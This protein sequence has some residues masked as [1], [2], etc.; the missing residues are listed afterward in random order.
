MQAKKP[1]VQDCEIKELLKDV[2]CF[3]LDMDGTFFLGDKLLPG[4]LTFMDF[5]QENGLEYLFLTNNSSSHAGLYAEKIGRMGFDVPVE[6]IFTSGAATTIYL[7]KR[8]PNA[9]V[10]L[11]GTQALEEEFRKS[12]FILTDDDPDFAVLGFDT[13][14]TYDKLVKIC[15]LVRAGKPYI[16]THPDINCPVPGGFIPDIGSFIALITSSTG[17]Q[18]DVIVGK[19][20]EHIV[21]A[22]VQ[23]TGFPKT[24]IAMIGDRLYTDIALGQAGICTILVLTGETQRSDLADSKFQPDIVVENLGELGNKLASK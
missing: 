11:V 24:Q 14:L 7:Q 13:S 10:Y 19:P 4:A 17:R 12:G 21:D 15:N 2:H 20:N 3:L 1:E 18:P 6:R 16:A 22:V 8:K 23:K 9:K 5:L